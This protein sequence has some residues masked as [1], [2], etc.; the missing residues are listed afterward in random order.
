MRSLWQSAFEASEGGPP[1][2]HANPI[3]AGI[4]AVVN[5]N[6]ELRK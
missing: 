4:L 1:R 2:P 6:A 5:G 3:T